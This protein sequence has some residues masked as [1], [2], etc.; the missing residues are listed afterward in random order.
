LKAS[1]IHEV[2]APGEPFADLHVHSDCSDGTERP[3]AVVERAASLGFSGLAI[4]DHDTVRGVAP[5]RSRAQ[6]LGLTL[7]S[8]VELS[9]TAEKGD[10]HILG[11]GVDVED[12]GLLDTLSGIETTR[13]ERV[14]RM[15]R[16]LNDLGVKVDLEAFFARY[17]EG[18]VGRLHVARFLMEAG[19]VKSRDEAFQRYLG[20]G[21]PA[22]ERVNAISPDEG[23]R[24]IRKAGGIPALA[25]PGRTH[26]DH[27]ISSLTSVGL[28][29]VEVYHS[30]HPPAAA[31]YDRELAARKG[32]LPV[33]GSDCHGAGKD[34]VLMG[35]VKVP[36]E[37][38]E[39]LQ[40]AG[41]REEYG[42]GGS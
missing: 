30:G 31:R 38:L 16:R 5:A 13:R 11:Y 32:L 23:I 7:I 37:Y 42:R 17:P 40:R 9:T 4:A 34:Q 25:H 21:R 1:Y 6:A 18:S 10:L 8:A 14:S 41:A 2:V 27:L 33:G 29:A 24:L 20:M 26:K 12:A 28:Q 36:M 19:H 35:R 15:L 39:V 22:Y 3:E